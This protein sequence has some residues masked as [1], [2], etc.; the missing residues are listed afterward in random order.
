[1]TLKPSGV[2]VVD[3]MAAFAGVSK[4]NKWTSLVLS[5]LAG[6]VKLKAVTADLCED[7][8]EV[9][10]EQFLVGARVE[11]ITK[12]AGQ[13]ILPHDGIPYQ[14][15]LLAFDPE[16]GRLVCEHDDPERF[17]KL[18][19]DR[20]QNVAEGVPEQKAIPCGHIYAGT[21][22]DWNVCHQPEPVKIT[23]EDIRRMDE[24]LMERVGQ[25]A[26]D[27]ETA[28]YAHARVNRCSAACS[29]AHTYVEGCLLANIVSDVPGQIMP[30]TCGSECA[31]ELGQHTNTVGTCLNNPTTGQAVEVV[32]PVCK[33]RGSLGRLVAHMAEAH[34]MEPD[35]PNAQWV[36]SKD[37]KNL[38]GRLISQQGEDLTEAYSEQEPAE[39]ESEFP[40]VPGV[41]YQVPQQRTE[42]D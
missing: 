2:A 39:E 22:C 19:R 30:P 17:L 27:V 15:C 16:L 18:Q 12:P 21:P 23:Q 11:A 36:S 5:P 29:E 20:V 26:E 31:P 28:G 32:C 34:E 6:M 9:L 7:C 10:T 1:M 3:A 38:D 40:A 24:G 33:G 37:G 41:D 4:F 25:L 35:Y 13:N 42:T 14:D 8:T